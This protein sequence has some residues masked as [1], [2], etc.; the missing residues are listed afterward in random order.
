M[1]NHE[2]GVSKVRFQNLDGSGRQRS[3]HAVQRLD[4][5]VIGMFPLDEMGKAGAQ[6]MSEQNPGS[7]VKPYEFGKNYTNTEGNS[8][9][10]GIQD[11]LHP[12]EAREYFK[13]A[14][15]TDPRIWMD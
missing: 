12:E 9:R 1:R 6:A 4:G 14:F 15:G 11:G 13:N 3:H 5:I 2:R 7:E 8:L 10:H